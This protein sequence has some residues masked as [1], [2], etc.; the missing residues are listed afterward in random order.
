[1]GRLT[2]SIN[3]TLDGCVDHQ[4]GIADDET[5][6]HFTRLLD[7]N[8][9]MLWGRTTYEMMEVYWPLVARG[10]V[11]APQALREWAVKLEAKPKYVVSA[12]RSDF[13]WTNSHHVAGELRTAVQEL[14]DRTPNGVLVGSGKLATELD[15]L[16]LID[17]YK[18]LIHPM[19]TGHGPT[20]YQGGL[21]GTRH[22]DLISATPLS[23]GVVAMHY[24]R[25]D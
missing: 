15:R 24:R 11:D 10:E 4:E 14:K 23:N 12:T 16:D 19:I 17:D 9:A 1:M 21:P 20:L 22:L 7:Q 13:P 8:G 6:A 5:H 25:A 18:F 3:V 2:F